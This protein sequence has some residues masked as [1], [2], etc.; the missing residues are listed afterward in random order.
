M[1]FVSVVHDRNHSIGDGLFAIYDILETRVI[2]AMHA[3]EELLHCVPSF[4]VQTNGD[5]QAEIIYCLT[6][7]TAD[8]APH[9]G[10]PGQRKFKL[11]KLYAPELFQ[12]MVG[13]YEHVSDIWG[14]VP[15]EL[16]MRVTRYNMQWAEERR[17]ARP[18]DNRYMMARQV[19]RRADMDDNVDEADEP[20]RQ[21]QRTVNGGASA[22]P[23]IPD[24]RYFPMHADMGNEYSTYD[25]AGHGAG[26]SARHFPL[27]FAQAAS[28][29]EP[30]Q[31]HVEPVQRWFP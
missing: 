5:D 14:E 20:P 15:D 24:E 11:Q 25:L 23:F 4:E 17:Q 18:P 27:N 16:M 19:R 7:H 10:M 6:Y 22:M 13:T 30:V 2:E 31:P 1:A 26:L 21:R 29:Y 9:W 28:N 8:D 12:H 3:G